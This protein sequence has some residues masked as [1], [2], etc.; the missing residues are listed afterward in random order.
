MSLESPLGRVLGLGSA[1]EGSDHWWSQRVSSVL[2]MLLGLWFI[3]ALATANGYTYLDMLRFVSQPWNG[4]LLSLMCASFAY[5]SYLGVQVVLEDYVHA[6]AIK[7]VS[8]LASRFV[9]LLVGFA[10]V[11]A[12]IRIGLGS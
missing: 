10:C 5:H 9:H 11:F 12:V 8:L 1:K 6:P 2:N 4:V 3:G 7:V